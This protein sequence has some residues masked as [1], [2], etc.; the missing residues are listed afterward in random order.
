MSNVDMLVRLV[1]SMGVVM[2]LMAVAA[3]VLRR[4]ADGAGR[5]RR[6]RGDAVELVAR[7]SLS[8]GA[9]VAVVRTG[10]KTLVLGV[11]DHNVSLLATNDAIDI[12]PEAAASP[13]YDN[14]LAGLAPSAPRAGR[15]PALAG[16]LRSAQVADRNRQAWKL[17]IES[18]RERTLRR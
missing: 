11:T 7:R 8:K 1:V 14:P 13:G 18:L 6:R 4:R 2:A 12:S 16:A 17:S 10:G 9:S 3:R 15:M 5:S